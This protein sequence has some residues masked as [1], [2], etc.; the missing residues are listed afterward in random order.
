MKILVGSLNKAKI[1]GVEGAFKRYFDDVSVKP[2]KVDSGVS[3]QPMTLDEVIKGSRT[4][5]IKATYTEEDWMYSVG[6]E[7]GMYKAG[8]IWV[9]VQVAYI[10]RKDGIESMGLSPAFPVPRNFV[11]KLLKC[12]YMELEDIINEYYGREK[13]GEEEGFI[14]LLTRNIVDRRCL[15]YYAVIMALTPFLNEELYR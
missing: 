15:T 9:D 2:I 3:P 12:E 8:E 7:A 5:A 11:E 14:G 10:V 4:R 1:M 6:I 13:I